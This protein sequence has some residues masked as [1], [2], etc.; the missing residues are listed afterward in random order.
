MAANMVSSYRLSV[1][2]RV[3]KCM[4]PTFRE[5]TSGNCKMR[6]EANAEQQL[7]R[8]KETAKTFRASF[9]IS[10]YETIFLIYTVKIDCLMF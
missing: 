2:R 5:M 9:R 4:P 3:V 1:D 8:E 7:Y 10:I 6:M